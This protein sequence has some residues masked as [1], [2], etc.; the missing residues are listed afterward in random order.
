MQTFTQMAL[1]RNGTCQFIHG[2]RRLTVAFK[3]DFD[4]TVHS[5]CNQ[6]ENHSHILSYMLHSK[7]CYTDFNFKS[8]KSPEI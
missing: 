1:S 6:H 7:A 5:L 2:L 4:R 3:T 8:A